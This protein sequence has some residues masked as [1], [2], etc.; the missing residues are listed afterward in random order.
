MKE[1]TPDRIC[2][3]S[4]MCAAVDLTIAIETKDRLRLQMAS[5]SV[6]ALA[7]T[8]PDFMTNLAA[9]REVAHA[10]MERDLSAKGKSPIV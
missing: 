9:L 3:V 2:E 5:M 1:L 6:R 8:Y 10:Q 7:G 4:L